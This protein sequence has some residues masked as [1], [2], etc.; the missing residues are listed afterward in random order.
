MTGQKKDDILS[1]LLSR[2][3]P[4]DGTCHANSGQCVARS[5]LLTKPH[6]CGMILAAVIYALSL[7]S[8]RCVAAHLAISF[9]L[10][11]QFIYDI[12]W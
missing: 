1:L 2:R 12:L 3:A 11:D 6:R 8:A 9:Y 10:T 7:G 4:W 5:I